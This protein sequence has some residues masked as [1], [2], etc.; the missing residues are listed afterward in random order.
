MYRVA[1]PE[2]P[3]YLNKNIM[4]TAYY[5]NKAGYIARFG[6]VD[7]VVVFDEDDYELRRF[8]TCRQCDERVPQGEV[9]PVCGGTTF[10]YK[11]SEDET[12]TEDIVQFDVNDP[13]QSSVIIAKRGQSIPYYKIGQLPFVIRNNITRVDSIYGVSDIDVLEN[14][15]DI[16][17]K[18]LF[19]MAQSVLKGGSFVTV[20]QGVNVPNTDEVLKVIRVADPRSAQIV[21]VTTVQSNIQQDDILQDRMYQI[22]RSSLGITDSYQGKRDPTAESGKAKELSAAQ[23]A[24]RMESKR[25]MKDAAYGDLYQ[26]MFK[27]LLAYCDEPRTF[28]RETPDGNIIEGKF[29]RYNFLAGEAVPE[30]EAPMVYYND[31]FIFSV[32]NASV[33]STN[34][35]AMW[36]ECVQNFSAGVYGN[37]ADPMTVLFF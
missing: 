13:E 9:C 29:S 33:L 35:D 20:P 7:D 26:L 8:R 3:E 25:R 1:I 12:L 6:W 23:A 4:I 15:Q 19:K 11:T 37:P 16:Q 34:R 10:V 24:S 30:G 31:R 14:S 27:F 17:N 2:G 28:T 5:F 32:D 36:K 22:G 18:L 21:N